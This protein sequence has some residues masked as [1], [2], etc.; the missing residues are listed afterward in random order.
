MSQSPV[1]ATSSSVVKSLFH[2]VTT[3][4]IALILSTLLG[5]KMNRD[6]VDINVIAERNSKKYMQGNFFKRINLE[7]MKTIYGN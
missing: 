1:Q 4:I 6:D 3:V 5:T 7:Q 2:V